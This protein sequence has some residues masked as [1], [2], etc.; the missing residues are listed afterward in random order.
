MPGPPP[1]TSLQN[2][3]RVWRLDSDGWRARVLEFVLVLTA[4]AV[5]VCSSIPGTFACDSRNTLADAE[6]VNT[7]E[8]IAVAMT[9]SQ[10]AALAKPWQKLPWHCVHI[11]TKTKYRRCTRE[12]MFLPMSAQTCA[13]LHMKSIAGSG[14]LR[15]S[16]PCVQHACNYGGSGNK[17][18]TANIHACLFVMY[19]P[20]PHGTRLDVRTHVYLRR[21]PPPSKS[22][23]PCP[24]P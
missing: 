19:M 6:P 12:S 2:L 10:A 17:K 23:P 21:P 11:G 20:Y 4:L 22:T 1:D 18:V 3:W 9:A 24:S 15:P 7:M 16:L 8:E 14:G 13:E 5:F